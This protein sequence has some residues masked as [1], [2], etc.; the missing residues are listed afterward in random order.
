MKR[1]IPALVE[2][3]EIEENVQLKVLRRIFIILLIV[4]LES[5]V[6]EEHLSSCN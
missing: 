2:K 1:L 3:S 6:F 5:I 4:P